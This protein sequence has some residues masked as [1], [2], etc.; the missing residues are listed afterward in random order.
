MN[1]GNGTF[2]APV[3]YQMTVFAEQLVLADMNG[4]AK[5]D[6][7]ALTRILRQAQAFG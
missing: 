7:V 1:N 4:D 3:T 6:L 2:A 5:L